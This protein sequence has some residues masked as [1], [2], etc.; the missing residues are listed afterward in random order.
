[1]SINAIEWI[2]GEAKKLR[3]ANPKKFVKYTDAVKAAAVNYRA[4][5][6]VKKAAPKRKAPV[7]KKIGAYKRKTLTKSQKQYNADVAKYKY[8]I[9][10]L[11]SKKVASGWEFKSDAMDAVSEYP[12]SGATIMTALQ[13]KKAGIDNPK[14]TWIDTVGVIKKTKAI[15]NATIKKIK[16][17]PNKPTPAVLR[18]V[19]NGNGTAKITTRGEGYALSRFDATRR[20]SVY[21]LVK[22]AYY[23]KFRSP[24]VSPNSAFFKKSLVNRTDFARDAYI[25]DKY[26]VRGLDYGNWVDQEDRANFVYALTLGLYDLQKLIGVDNIGKKT[27]I[28]EYGA[29][30]LKTAAAYFRPQTFNIGIK[31]FPRAD[32][33][34]E[35]G[36]TL[37]KT[38][39]SELSRSGLNTQ[40]QLT[41]SG[42]VALIKQ[43]G[44]WGSFG[45]E[46]GHF[47]DFYLG[48][49]SSTKNAFGTGRLPLANG[50]V[51]VLNAQTLGSY[52]GINMAS[53]AGNAAFEVLTALYYKKITDKAYLKKY[54]L[55]PTLAWY[56]Q[57]TNLSRL[58]YACQWYGGGKTDYWLSTCEVWARIF[59]VYIQSELG[60]KGINNTFLVSARKKYSRQY[61]L[62]AGVIKKST[63]T[64]S[65]YLPETDIKKA[66]K[67]IQNFLHIFANTK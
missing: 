16:L 18:G 7:A 17:K 54:N 45:H 53:S 26:G 11:K 65:F 19:G 67:Q 9:V 10:E 3:A 44:S 66:K 41:S 27:L 35:R 57:S 43:Q 2:A 12:K 13:L 6:G 20:R 36:N 28:V 46:F 63:P 25:M 21:E 64:A 29:G 61:F 40:K 15:K 22:N 8:F 30:G 51:F 37:S 14:N 42:K 33:Y 34:E 4:K 47:I 60:A 58:F 52:F 48:K 23:D 5:F 31:R 49:V 56:T 59:E 38:D 1:M 39:Y 62:E 32:R 50:R 24:R 55:S